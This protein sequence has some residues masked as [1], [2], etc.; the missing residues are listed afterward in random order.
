MLLK[1]DPMIS[2]Q[3]F[4]KLT[5]FHHLV[6][7]TQCGI[8]CV[9][10]YVALLMFFCTCTYIVKKLNIIDT[11]TVWVINFEGLNFCGLGSWDDFVGLYFYGIATLIT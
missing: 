8:Q 1:Y 4:I 10:R 3:V 11:A 9:M 6:H 2:Q 5:V 7:T